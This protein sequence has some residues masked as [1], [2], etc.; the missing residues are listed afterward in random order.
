M[1]L[2]ETLNTPVG[3]LFQSEPATEEGTQVP[4]QEEMPSVPEQEEPTVPPVV[5]EPMDEAP[6]QKI[7]GME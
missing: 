1:G 2:M 6:E 3:Q 5:E 7:E 4:S